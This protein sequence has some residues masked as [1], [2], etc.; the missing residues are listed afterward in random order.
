MYRENKWEL[1]FWFDFVWEVKKA[2]I[3]FHLPAD[4]APLFL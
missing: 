2:I 4:K 1:Y 3:I